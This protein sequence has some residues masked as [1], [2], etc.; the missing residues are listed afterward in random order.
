MISAVSD[1]ASFIIESIILV[2]AVVSLSL[3]WWS[4]R[5]GSPL[6]AL[7]GRW[8]RWLFLSML[9]GWITYLFNWTGYSYPVLVAVS[10][11]V[12]FFLE[13][14]YNWIA[15][16]ALSRSELPLFPKFEENTRGDEWPSQPAFIHLKDWLRQ[17]GFHKKEALVS[18]IAEQVLMRVSVYDNEDQ[19]IRLQV[20]FLPNASGHTSVCFTCISTTRQGDTIL[21]DNLYLPFGGFY[22]E[23]WDVERSPWTRSIEALL[24]RHRARVD[25]KAEELIPFI[26]SPLNQINSDQRTVEQLNRDLGFLHDSSE[27]EEL[28]RLTGAGRARVW[29]EV[30]T[31]SYLGMPLSYN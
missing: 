1:S 22:P 26:I 10:A 15:I 18:V 17:N 8:V 20:M 23:N 6:V 7:F 5:T 21:T 3:S 16:S 30:W 13:T 14:L 12:W 27:E 11:L 19:T 28:G 4:G 9:F 25:A 24:G 31:L 2:V 29:Q